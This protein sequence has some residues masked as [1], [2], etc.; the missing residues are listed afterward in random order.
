MFSLLKLH[1]DNV[2]DILEE[3]DLHDENEQQRE[4]DHVELDATDDGVVGRLVAVKVEVD[5]R[6]AD[7]AEDGVVDGDG[8]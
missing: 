1:V 5:E 7:D 6:G 2:E 8:E 4:E 3:T